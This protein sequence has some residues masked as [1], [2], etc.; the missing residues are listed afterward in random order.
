MVVCLQTQT[1]LSHQNPICIIEPETS[2]L[3][4]RSI[5]QW[6]YACKHTKE[7]FPS[8]CITV[9]SEAC[10]GKTK[11]AKVNLKGKQWIRCIANDRSQEQF[12][13]F[14]VMQT[15]N[16]RHL[17][18]PAFV[19]APIRSVNN[20]ARQANRQKKFTRVRLRRHSRNT[21]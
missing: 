18:T 9:A 20:N 6:W 17:R 3:K 13:S 10:D 19:A 8:S 15:Q 1:A 12:V 16:Y 11:S 14:H 4:C 21:G 2:N 7:N 5:C